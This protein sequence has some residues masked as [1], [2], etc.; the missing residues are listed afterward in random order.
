MF[1]PKLSNQ[2]IGC[3]HSKAPTV[4]TA[5]NQPKIGSPARRPGQVD[6]FG[7]ELAELKTRQDSLRLTLRQVGE[8]FLAL[9]QKEIQP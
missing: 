4:G 3:Y 2:E 5:G 8:Q 1:L 6:D 7:R 9:A